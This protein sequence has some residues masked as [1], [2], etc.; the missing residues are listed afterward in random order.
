MLWPNGEYVYVFD[1]KLLPTARQNI[2]SAFKM[3]EDEVPCIKFVPATKDSQDYVIHTSTGANQYVLLIMQSWFIGRVNG[4]WW[5][6]R[7]NNYSTTVNNCDLR[8]VKS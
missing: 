2:L 8:N 7:I 3:I 6:Q 4:V 5:T 1:N